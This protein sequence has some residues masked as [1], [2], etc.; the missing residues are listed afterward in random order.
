[1][2][3]A[4]TD[5]GFEVSGLPDWSLTGPAAQVAS[6]VHGG[7]NALRLRALNGFG[8]ATQSR[9]DQVVSVVP[10]TAYPFSVWVYPTGSNNAGMRLRLYVDGALHAEVAKTA[11]VADTWQQ[12]SPPDVSV[13][14]AVSITLSLRAVYVGGGIEILST[15]FVL[16]DA[17]LVEAAAVAVT[18]AIRDALVV[19]MAAI[20]GTGIFVTTIAAAYKQ[21]LALAERATPSSAL[22]PNQGGQA[23][24]ATIDG[25]RGEAAQVYTAEIVVKSSTPLDDVMDY[26]D[27]LRNA[28]ERPTSS[29][30]A[31]S[32]DNWKVERV[33]VVEWEP[34][35]TGADIANGYGIYHAQ[36]EA[37][38][39]YERGNA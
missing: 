39:I 5:G 13:G 11:L 23:D 30:R 25:R 28:V 18:K 2:P 14:A 17:E 3:N 12:W 7:E 15:D 26:L 35:M 24:N 9:A 34:V 1:M 22:V 36:I 16:D 20:D 33:Q 37:T 38:Y 29:T 19:D 8:G 32:G 6:P 31:A 4:L 27:D 21:P 10:E